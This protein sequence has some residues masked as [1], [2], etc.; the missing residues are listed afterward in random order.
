MDNI[1]EVFLF[2]NFDVCVVKQKQKT[3]K[4]PVSCSFSI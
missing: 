3:K 2:L 4:K 1:Y